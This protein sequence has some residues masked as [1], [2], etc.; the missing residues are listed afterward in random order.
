MNN[1]GFAVSGFVYTILIIFIGLLIAILALLNSRKTVLDNLKNKILGDVNTTTLIGEVILDET[2]DI[3]EYSAPVNGY[4]HF[5]VSSPKINT[6]N[7]STISFD[8]YLKKGETIYILNGSSNYNNGNTEIRKT[9]TADVIVI[10]S[11]DKTKNYVNEVV[12]NVVISNVSIT[13]NNYNSSVGQ[14]V[15]NYVNKAKQNTNLNQVK[16]IK[17]CVNGNSVDNVAAWSEI[18]AILNGENKALN[19][20]VEITVDGQPRVLSN[21]NSIVDNNSHTFL[22]IN[23]TGEVCVTID[24]EIPRNLDSIS[25]LH[26]LN[27]TFYNSK[28]YVSKDGINYNLIRNYEKAEDRNG[29]IISAYDTVQ[30]ELV[31]DI[32]VP[33]K[34]FDGATWLRVFHHN[35]LG[36]TILWDAKEQAGVDKG[37][38]SPHKQSIL[39]NL[40]NYKNSSGKFEFLLEYSDRDG[41]NRWIQTSNPTTTIEKVTG[42]EAIKISWNQNNWYGLAKSNSNAT[43]IDGTAGNSNSYSIGATKTWNNGIPANDSISAKEIVDLWIRIDNLR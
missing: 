35:N 40:S 23:E 8:I 31:G 25:I 27:T 18:K 17:D 11:G 30:V 43:F 28:T 10:S 3:L 24:L 41:Y 9:K 38:N 1:K 13:E 34:V 32:Y 4:Y 42:Y 19:K 36:G 21:V 33:V 26:K 15:I 39:Y 29:L 37:H 5:D 2:R 22:N 20:N 12:G 6:T 14:V 16:Y 7:G